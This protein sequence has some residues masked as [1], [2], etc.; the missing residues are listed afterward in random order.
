MHMSE[1][2]TD[3]NRAAH[4]ARE[5]RVIE[6]EDPATGA[7]LGFVPVDGPEGVRRAVEAARAAQTAWAEASFTARRRVLGRILEHVVT[8]ADELVEIVCRDAGKTR[9][10][11]IM[12]EIWPVLEKLRWTM[13]QGERHLRPER[14]PSG[15]FPH[16]RASIRYA[17]RGVVGIVAPWNYPLQNVLGPAIPALFA[18][19]AVVLKVSEAVAFSSARFQRIFDEAF[20]AEGFSRDLVR[21]VNGFVPTGAALVGA[22]VDLLIFTGSMENGKKIIAES[23]ETLTPV[24]LELG[25][26]DPLIVCDDAA[27]PQAVHAALVGVFIAAGQNCMA[28]ERVLVFDAVY[29]DFV[30]GVTAPSCGR[31]RP[32]ETRPSTWAPASPR[33]RW[34][35]WSAWWRTPSRGGRARSSA[36]SVGRGRGTSS[37]PPCSWT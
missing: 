24:I 9:E 11:A 20:E 32:W 17:P 4:P 13:A 25:G 35:W 10:N 28:A 36:A 18:G 15:I 1:T 23:A 3:P 21:L 7:S 5:P 19:N 30:R 31:A 26:K 6:C 33:P 34:R 14:M 12:G 16:K 29:D 37:S 22:G 27:L 2:P 8:H